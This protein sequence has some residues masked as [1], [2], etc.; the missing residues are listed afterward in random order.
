MPVSVY[1]EQK[2]ASD[3]MFLALAGLYRRNEGRIKKMPYPCLYLEDDQIALRDAFHR[4]RVFLLHSDGVDIRDPN[5]LVNFLSHKY[6]SCEP[7]L[8]ALLDYY[9]HLTGQSLQSGLPIICT[10]VSINFWHK[11]FSGATQISLDDHWKHLGITVGIITRNR[12][13]DLHE[14]LSSLTN[15]IRPADEVLIVVMKS[16]K[17]YTREDIVEIQCHGGYF[18]LKKI[19]LYI[20]ELMILKD[21]TS[22]RVSLALAHLQPGDLWEDRGICFYKC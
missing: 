15:Q 6:P 11:C 10:V 14:M 19:L 8:N 13:A 22:R 20:E 18:V 12:S 4:M 9:L 2:A 17:T 5:L 16:P 3:R 1:Q 7:F 21:E